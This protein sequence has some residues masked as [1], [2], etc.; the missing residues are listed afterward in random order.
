MNYKNIFLFNAQQST[1]VAAP[2]PEVESEESLKE[3]GGEANPSG[4][5]VVNRK[6]IFVR[7]I[8]SLPAVF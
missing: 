3:G 5:Q 6:V 2:E 4:L 8:I 7:S 1:A